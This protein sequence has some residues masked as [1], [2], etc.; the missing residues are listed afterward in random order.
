MTTL[1]VDLKD[2]IS[3]HSKKEGSYLL[4]I[5]LGITLLIE[6]ASDWIPTINR[7]WDFEYCFSYTPYK[8]IKVGYVN[9]TRTG[10]STPGYYLYIEDMCFMR[11]CCSLPFK[12]YKC[13]FIEG[14][15]KLRCIQKNQELARKRE[16]RKQNEKN[17]IL[18]VHEL[19]TSLRSLN[20]DH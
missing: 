7:V 1:R 11:V 3:K 8:N 15:E 18:K 16:T 12:S 20:A 10:L 4:D 13:K 2:L 6:N 19:T 14:I 17:M 5:I 9:R